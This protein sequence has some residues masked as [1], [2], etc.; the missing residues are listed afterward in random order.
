MYRAGLSTDRI[1]VVCQANVRSVRRVIGQLKK[2]DP[3]L[4]VTH[5]ANKPRTRPSS[6]N[7]LLRW[8][9]RWQGAAEFVEAH[10]RLPLNRRSSREESRLAT[11]FSVQ[12][13][14]ASQGL[15]SETQ[16]ELL[17][18]IPAWRRPAGVLQAE[19]RWHSRLYQVVG[20]FSQEHRLPSLHLPRDAHERALAVWVH[21][22]RQALKA[23]S[24]DPERVALLDERLPE[25][26]LDQRRRE[27]R[28]RRGWK[29][30]S[31]LRGPSAEGA[32]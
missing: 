18:R 1:A 28:S 9:E 10:G 7:A 8:R 20:F 5:E 15:L 22:Q 32:R 14:K 27:A 29:T 3:L 12:R 24:L 30:P 16:L 26:R 23:G 13:Q 2:Q 31:S 21:D 4:Q 6:E 17:D 11:W 25:W 19:A